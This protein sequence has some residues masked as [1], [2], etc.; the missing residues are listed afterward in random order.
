MVCTTA[1]PT[2]SRKWSHGPAQWSKEWN[3]VL[4][5]LVAVISIPALAFILF[6]GHIVHFVYGSSFSGATDTLSLLGPATFALCIGYGYGIGLT[7]LGL[8]RRQ[9]VISLVALAFNVCFN[10]WLIPPLGGSGAALATLISAVVYVS[11][12]HTVLRIRIKHEIGTVE[13]E[14]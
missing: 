4:V 14:S 3:H 7:S 5:M 10:L 11:L 9:L 12:A 2:L 1:L 8:E 13:E 6:P